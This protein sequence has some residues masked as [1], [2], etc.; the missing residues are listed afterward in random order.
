VDARATSE[1]PAT[2][3]K[4]GRRK[5]RP[6]FCFADD[7]HRAFAAPVRHG[8]PRVFRSGKDPIGS[9]TSFLSFSSSSS[10]W[11]VLL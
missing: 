2:A 6:F 10:P 7:E 3:T 8:V 5:H 4:K 9:I 11:Y 1:N